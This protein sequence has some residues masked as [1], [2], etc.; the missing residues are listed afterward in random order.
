MRRLFTT[1]VLII[2]AFHMGAYVGKENMNKFY[3]IGKKVVVLTKDA[4]VWATTQW[5]SKEND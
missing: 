4:V 3:S 1:I 5:S 2:I